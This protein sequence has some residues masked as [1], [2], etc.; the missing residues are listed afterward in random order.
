[1][2]DHLRIV[3]WLHLALGALGVVTG[4]F[5]FGVMGSVGI[6]TGDA[7]DGTTLA[8]IGGLLAGFFTLMSVPALVGGWGLLQRRHWARIL[9]LILSFMNLFGFPVGTLIGGYSIWVLMH[10]ETKALL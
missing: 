2:Q 5:V 6:M 1:M 4:L 7:R 10:D 9:V 3:A 8:V